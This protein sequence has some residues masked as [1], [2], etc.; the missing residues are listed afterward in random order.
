MKLKVIK[1]DL[2]P[3]VEPTGYDVGFDVRLKN[4]RSFYVHTIVD[5][6]GLEGGETDEEITQIAYEQLEAQI[7]DKA[8]E[9]SYI[10]SVIGIEIHVDSEY[11]TKAMDID[12]RVMNLEETIDTMLGGEVNE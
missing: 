6:E 4:G 8:G 9:L 1:Y 7:A 12:S 3:A 11:E 5:L 2:Y 10:P